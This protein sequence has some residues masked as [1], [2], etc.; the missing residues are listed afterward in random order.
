MFDPTE[1]EEEISPPKDEVVTDQAEVATA[2]V[3]GYEWHKNAIW[4]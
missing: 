2:E 1:V 4:F 3:S